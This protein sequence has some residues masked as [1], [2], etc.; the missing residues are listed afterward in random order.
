MAIDLEV[1]EW[2]SYSPAP[3]VQLALPGMLARRTSYTAASGVV[4][5]SAGVRAV[6]FINRGDAG[7]LTWGLTAGLGAAA[8]GNPLAVYLASGDVLNVGLSADVNSSLCS[9]SFA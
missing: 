8:I 7:W 5:F 6:S 1:R 9:F 3:G 2:S 4:A